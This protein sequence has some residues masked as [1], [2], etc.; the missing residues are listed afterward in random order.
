M[1]RQIF[2]V[3]VAASL[4]SACQT[5]VVRTRVVREWPADEISEVRLRGLNGRVKLEGDA[6][7]KVLLVAEIHATG[8]PA[9][10]ALERGLIDTSLQ[11]QT[12][13]IR[14]KTLS[15]KVIEIVPFFNTGQLRVDYLLRVPETTDVS[16]T[17]SA[18][19]IESRGVSG[20]LN[21]ETINGAIRVETARAQLEA[22][23]VN[24]AIRAI[25]TEE[26]RGAQLRTV[27]GSIKLTVPP[28]SSIDAQVDQVNGAFQTNI[29]VHVSSMPGNGGLTG[30]VEGGEFPLEVSTVNGSVTLERRELD[31]PTRP[32]IPEAPPSPPTPG[33]RPVPPAQPSNSRV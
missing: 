9:R 2:A 17:T 26:F 16:V 4:V 8:R 11:G 12:L 28:G 7:G 5:Q 6:S 27:N 21:L 22:K 10:E 23:T 1:R 32:P 30:T 24:G 13:E 18:G 15:R 3:V 29:P 20:F 25:F 31:M 14:E 19:T 33:V